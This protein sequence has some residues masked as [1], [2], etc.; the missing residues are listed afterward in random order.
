MAKLTRIDLVMSRGGGTTAANA[1][2][3]ASATGAS[4]ATEV[5]AWVLFRGRCFPV[6]RFALTD[7][8]PASSGLLRALRKKGG[9]VAS[10]PEWVYRKGNTTAAREHFASALIRENAVMR[11]LPPVQRLDAAKRW[12]DNAIAVAQRV[13]TLGDFNVRTALGHQRAWRAVLDSASTP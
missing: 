12:L 4:V 7:E 10:V 2:C 9:V 8:T 13:S 11:A 3:C 5:L 1:G 6:S